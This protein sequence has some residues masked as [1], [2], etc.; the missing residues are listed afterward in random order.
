MSYTDI[1][2][3]AAA[4]VEKEGRMIGREAEGEMLANQ[5]RS[6]EHSKRKEIIMCCV[7]MY[8]NASFLYRILN[9]T[10]RESNNS[11]T[12]TLGP[13]CYFLKCYPEALGH[14]YYVGITYRGIK[15]D[16]VAIEIYKQAV[17]KTFLCYGANKALRKGDL[18]KVDTF[19]A[20]CYFLSLMNDIKSLI[21]KCHMQ[22]V[23]RS[24]TLASDEIQMYQSSVGTY[25]AWEKFSSTS[26]VR[27][28]AE[29]FGPVLFII[30]CFG[31]L[32]HDCGIYI[33]SLSKFHDE[34][35]I[36]PQPGTNFRV[37]KMKYDEETT[38]YRFYLT[39]V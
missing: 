29:N 17:D 3:Q 24:M 7:R 2:Q 33:S 26:K 20:Y 34:K 15:L 28:E 10:M 16:E 9:K 32:R 21:S 14:D 5:L 35:E 6:V 18:S 22:T 11:K 13:Y 4:G 19:D 25:K 30:L 38:R 8:T 39:V 37:D 31:H 27:S 1:F 23:Y 36:L 12:G